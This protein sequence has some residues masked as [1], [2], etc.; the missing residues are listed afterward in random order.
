MPPSRVGPEGAGRYGEDWLPI[1]N[2][3]HSRPPEPLQGFAPF[4]ALEFGHLIAC[5][6][7][8]LGLSQGFQPLETAPFT[9]A[10]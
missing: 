3:A 1:L 6:E 7:G 8:A 4:G 5:P 2:R 9:V 10:P